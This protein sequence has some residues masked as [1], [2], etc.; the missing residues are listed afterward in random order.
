MIFFV[1]FVG[2]PPTACLNIILWLC[3]LL[4]FNAAAA[5][6]QNY[7]LEPVNL[8]SPR[9]TLRTFI[10]NA[11]NAEKEFKQSGYRTKDALKYI[12]RAASTFD[13]QEI[14]PTLHKEVGYDSTLRLKAILDFIEVPDLDTIPGSEDF[15]DK[16]DL[17]WR[18]P[19]TD[20]SIARITEGPRRG[21]WLF[22]AATVSQIEDYYDLI[23]DLSPED[24]V[25]EWIYEKYIYSPGRMIPVKMINALPRWMRTGVFEQ[26]LWQ[27]SL[28]LL[29]L[30]VGAIALVGSWQLWTPLIKKLESESR[31]WRWER[32]VYPIFGIVIVYGLLYFI[33]EQ[34]N[35][36]GSVMIVLAIVLKALITVFGSWLV[37]ICGEIIIEGIAKI[38]QIKSTRIATDVTRLVIRV[39]SFIILFILLYNVADRFGIPVT[40]V[41]ASAGIAG[42]A[43][44]LAAKDTLSN[45]FG[46]VTIFMDRPF[47]TGDYIVLDNNE[48]GEVVQIGLRSTRIQTRDDVMIT[49]PNA[50]ITNSRIVN[51]SSPEP[52][53]RVR[54]QI[55]VAYGSDIDKVEKIILEQVASNPLAET[56]P[57]PH[58]RF[59]QFGE[60]SLNFELLCWAKRPHD[61][62]RLLHGLNSG[63]YNAFNK[64][65]IKIPFPQRDLHLKQE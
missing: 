18:I 54:V 32:M 42:V 15:K 2:A 43:V 49:I 28:L 35:I 45:L 16:D 57:E 37:L 4:P 41:F 21:A 50:I 62:S 12:R 24:K 14:S 29:T 13:M 9:A 60:S 59:R 27:W 22:T 20:I 30:V 51:Q 47:T 19:H 7:P 64:A 61:R 1:S 8:S 39:I 23:K 6:S 44:A 63:I 38:E 3:L 33:S 58:V 26:T 36:T 31:R 40:A 48:R 53:F 56:H 46:G 10:S 55:G 17:T 65:G 11:E 5:P 34:I 52:N 25:S